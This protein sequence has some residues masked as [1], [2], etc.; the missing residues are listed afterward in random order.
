MAATTRIGVVGLNVRAERVVLPGLVGSPRGALAALCSRDIAKA[1]AFA[2][3]YPGCRAFGDYA[4][5]LRDGEIDAVVVL[6]PTERHADMSLAAIERGLAVC[7]EKPLA[8]TL[9]DARA[10]AAAAAERGV[11]TAVNFTYRTTTAHRALAQQIETAQLGNLLTAEVSYRQ[12]R[13]LWEERSRRETLLDVGSHAVDALL[14]WSELAGAGR[15]IGVAAMAS[16]PIDPVLG[17]FR[18]AW[19]LLIRLDGGAHATVQASRIAAGTRNAM[20]ATL[21][22]SEGA[23][24][25]TFETDQ[26]RVEACGVGP[27][28]QWRDLPIP[29]ELVLGYETFPRVHFDRLVGALRGEEAFPDFTHGARVQAVL[30]AAISSAGGGGVVPLAL[31]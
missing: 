28:D 27:S 17:S 23:L 30:E 19:D 26:H 25:L 16:A 2:A 3:A 21:N 24:R 22:G 31:D 7:C 4:T 10:M 6:T 8:A 29:P 5:M 11:R 1:R 12:G 20:V 13:A 9:A 14:W 15:P 18:L